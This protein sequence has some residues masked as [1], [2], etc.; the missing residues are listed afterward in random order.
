MELAIIPG[1]ELAGA[2][3]DQLAC[4]DKPAARK[5]I[6]LQ[7]G[8]QGEGIFGAQAVD[9]ARLIRADDIRQLGRQVLLRCNG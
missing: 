5:R 4:F 6:A 8:Q 3:H 1:D 9:Q 2:P 7:A